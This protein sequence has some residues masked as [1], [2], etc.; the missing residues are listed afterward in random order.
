MP[1]A[2]NRRTGG[3]WDICDRCGFQFPISQLVKQKGLLVCIRRCFD[4]LTVE[5]RP[6]IIEQILGT[7]VDQ[8]GVDLRVVDRGF[9]DLGSD[10]GVS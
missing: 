9:F 2:L 10:E 1:N 5:R 7:G 8:E 4:D 6:Y 3:Q